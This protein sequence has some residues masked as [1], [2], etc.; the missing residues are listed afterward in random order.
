M[1]ITDYMYCGVDNKLFSREKDKRVARDNLI[2]ILSTSFM[3][4]NPLEGQEYTKNKNMNDL[5]QKWMRYYYKALVESKILIS[6]TILES[7]GYNKLLKRV[8][9]E[10]LE[11]HDYK[12][13][14]TDF[15]DLYLILIM[16]S[17]EAAL[18]SL[19]NKKI[20]FNKN[21]FSELDFNLK[22]EL[23]LELDKLYKIKVM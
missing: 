15:N 22:L 18:V 16:K 21:D 3:W 17:L 1:D 2:N 11:H 14:S 4:I 19:L 10:L 9:T 20:K 6:N 5:V 12:I 13:I 23:E 7:G 8:R